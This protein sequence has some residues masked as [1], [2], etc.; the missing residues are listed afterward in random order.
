MKKIVVSILTVVIMLTVGVKILKADSPDMYTP[1]NETKCSYVTG[2]EG[3]NNYV[4]S[5]CFHVDSDNNGICDG[6]GICENNVSYMQ[7]MAIIVIFVVSSNCNHRHNSCHYSD[8]N[9]DGI[10]DN[11][12]SHHRQ[13]NRHH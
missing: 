5:G 13:H 1:E 3:V 7:I 10:C 8:S 6:C 4:N 11:R 12:H 2:K 9:S